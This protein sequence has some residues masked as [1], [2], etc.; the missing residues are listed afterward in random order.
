MTR[1]LPWLVTLALIAAA[2]AEATLVAQD[3]IFQGDSRITFDTATSLQW[4]DVN[5]TQGL[6]FNAILAGAGDGDNQAGPG[7]WVADGWRH[8][9]FG[10]VCGLFE[11]RTGP[12]PH[13]TP[14]PSIG[15][16]DGVAELQAFLGVTTADEDPLGP[17]EETEG[18]LDGGRA[19]LARYLMVEASGAAVG[20]VEFDR[21]VGE[22]DHGHFLVRLPEPRMALIVGVFASLWLVRSRLRRRGSRTLGLTLVL[23]FALPGGGGVRAV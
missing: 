9:T 14:P 21:D 23:G 11:P 12:I 3:L 8:A 16:Y 19:G 18:F 4:L 17:Y 1:S 13:C 6:S 22:L 10:E 2:R 7:G 15:N 5:E 20:L